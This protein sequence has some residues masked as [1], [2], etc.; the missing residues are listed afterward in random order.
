MFVYLGFEIRRSGGIYTADSDHL[1]WINRDGELQE[2]VGPIIVEAICK[3]IEEGDPDEWAWR[4]DDTPN[5]IRKLYQKR[6]ATRHLTC[7]EFVEQFQCQWKVSPASVCDL[8]QFVSAR[9]FQIWQATDCL[10]LG[11]SAVVLV[12]PWNKSKEYEVTK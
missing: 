10:F 8:F 2:D 7:R 6:R 5:S 1:G 12:D 11:G 3:C 9:E 4:I